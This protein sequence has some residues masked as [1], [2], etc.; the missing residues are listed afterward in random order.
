M[1][2]EKY[3]VQHKKYLDMCHKDFYNAGRIALYNYRYD[4]DDVIEQVLDITNNL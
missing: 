1:P 3:R 2:S 4:I